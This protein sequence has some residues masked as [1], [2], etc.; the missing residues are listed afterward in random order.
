MDRLQELRRSMQAFPRYNLK[1][2][3]LNIYGH[4][5]KS[6]FLI[7]FGIW[8]IK[9]YIWVTVICQWMNS[10]IIFGCFLTICQTNKL[11][12]MPQFS[13]VLCSI[14]HR[15]VAFTVT[16]FYPLAKC[17]PL[18]YHLHIG[19]VAGRTGSSNLIIR[20]SKLI[21]VTLCVVEITVMIFTD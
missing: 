3:V 20:L 6:A 18:A 1:S 17:S 7:I 11:N 19:L 14:P 12:S 5:W 2:V 9:I 8:Q 16:G 15:I 13:T 4:A 21:L 10:G